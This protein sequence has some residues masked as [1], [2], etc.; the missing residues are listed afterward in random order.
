MA[1]LIKGNIPFDLVSS[2]LDKN[3]NKFKN[4]LNE[5]QIINISTKNLKFI[6]IQKLIY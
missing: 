1:L 6:N 4:V 3:F 5:D 2:S